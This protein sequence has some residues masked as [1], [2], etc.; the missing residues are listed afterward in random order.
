MSKM[1]SVR[2]DVDAVYLRKLV[3]AAGGRWNRSR[4]VWELAYRDVVDL[5]LTD[6]MVAEGRENV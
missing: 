4:K 3:K 6:R 2:V 1:V 5:G